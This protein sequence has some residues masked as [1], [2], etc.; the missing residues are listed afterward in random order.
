MSHRNARLTVHGRRLLIERVESGMPVA[1]AAKTLGVS[2]QCGHKWVR[3]FREE[4]PAG[5]EDRSSR[6]HTMPNRTPAN[7]ETR[8]V[9]ARREHRRGQDW[10]AAETGVPA[11][12][13]NRILHR[14][15]LPRLAEC[16]P[17]TGGKIR[18]SKT[19]TIRYE[20]DTPGDLV[21]VDVK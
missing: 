9:E 8:V 16:D 12:T 11:R 17:L 19:T 14:H 2:R 3:R 7:V 13:V 6:P 10:I 15:Q 1:H 5:L 21:H 4:G 20:R 18:A